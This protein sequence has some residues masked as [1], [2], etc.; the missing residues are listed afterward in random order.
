MVKTQNLWNMRQHA[1]EFCSD[2]HKRCIHSMN[3]IFTVL[4]YIFN[5]FIRIYVLIYVLIVLSKFWKKVK[6]FIY[7]PLKIRLI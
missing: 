5:T 7:V 2:L 6:K 1:L 3:A 4:F